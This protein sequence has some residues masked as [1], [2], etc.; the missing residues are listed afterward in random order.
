MPSG[1]IHDKIAIISII[2]IFF[3][4]YILL[5]FNF[6]KCLILTICILFSQLMFGPDLDA[7]STQ[8]K[9][10]GLIKWIWLPY[11]KIFRHRSKFSHG[12][13]LGP[14]LRCIYLVGIILLIFIGINFF[15]YNYFGTNLALKMINAG[16]AGISYIQILK[17][18][19]TLILSGFFIGA[20]I[21]TLTDKITSFFKNIL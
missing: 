17:P 4:G 1:K 13:L 2:P 12:L 10:W 8:Y 11:R 21:H 15:I 5:N 16:K 19:I 20:A 18:Y 3:T 9:R 7:K 14:A 6:I